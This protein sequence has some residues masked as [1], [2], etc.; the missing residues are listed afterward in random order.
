MRINARSIFSFLFFALLIISLAGGLFWANLNFVQRVPGGADFTILWKGARNFMM[1]GVTPYGTLTTLNIQNLVYGRAARP[2]Q[3]PLRVGAPFYIVLLFMPFGAIADLAIARALWMMALEAALVGLVFLSLHLSRWKSGP[4]Y[5]ILLMFF[6]VFWA[7]AG[8]ALFSGS[9][10]VFQTLM[11]LGAFRA[12]EFNSD[13]LAGMLIFLAAVNI[14]ATGPVILLA[15]F[16]AVSVG[17]WRI[18]GGFWMAAFLLFGLAMLFMPSWPLEF[19]RAVL[20][21]WRSQPLPGGFSLLETWFPG[22]GT[23]LAQGTA[24]TAAVILA[25]EWRGVFGRDIR[26]LFWTASLTAAMTPLLGLPFSFAWLT[27]SF[28]AFVLIL[29]VMELRWGI[30][31]RIGAIALLL[32]TFAA[33]WAVVNANLSAGWYVFGAPVVLVIFLYWVRWWA[34]RPPRLWADSVIGR[35]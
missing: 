28:P 19:L 12:I 17:R 20:A 8:W 4:L 32:S 11:L 1:Q 2:D 15:L 25:F 33:L 22:V 16:W 35:D 10:I 3:N 5:L 13:E 6:G 24:I 21:T 30:L 34:I 18:W 7:P 9:T 27:F 14:E 29:S 31:G 26:W 23:R